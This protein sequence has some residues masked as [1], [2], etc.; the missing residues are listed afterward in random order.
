MFTLFEIYNEINNHAVETILTDR[1]IE[2]NINYIRK[3]N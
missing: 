1:N 3:K 2:E